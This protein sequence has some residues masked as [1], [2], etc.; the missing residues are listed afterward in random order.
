MLGSSI[1]VGADS[2]S[3]EIPEDGTRLKGGAQSWYD[4]QG[5]RQNC[6]F[7]NQ[8]WKQAPSNMKFKTAEFSERTQR[9]WERPR[10]ERAD[11][12]IWS[13]DCRNRNRASTKHNYS[14]DKMLT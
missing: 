1:L 13:Q 3:G 5:L 7:G 9:R 6:R 12:N 8:T 11:K 2:G 14:V 10:E 4:P